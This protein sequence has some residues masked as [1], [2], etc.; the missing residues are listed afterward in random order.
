MPFNISYDLYHI[1]LIHRKLSSEKE[2]IKF[3]LTGLNKSR[4]GE[5]FNQDF[6]WSSFVTI[7]GN[8]E[9]LPTFESKDHFNF[10]EDQSPISMNNNRVFGESHNC[11]VEGCSMTDHFDSNNLDREY[12]AIKFQ[13]LMMDAHGC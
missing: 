3:N 10:G 9:T 7:S 4:H 1:I 13:A 11:L 6:H 5:N 12:D 8:E 2:N